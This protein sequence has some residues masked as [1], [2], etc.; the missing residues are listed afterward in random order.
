MIPIIDAP[1]APRL[2][3]LR[4]ALTVV[5]LLFSTVVFAADSWVSVASSEGS[6]PLVAGNSAAPLF[7]SPEDHAGV[8]KVAAHLQA[9]IL[10]VS[11]KEPLLNSRDVP[12]GELVVIIGTLGKS[13]LIDKLAASGKIDVATVMGRWETFGI[14]SVE[15]PMPEVGRALVIFGSDKRGTIYGMYEL[16][17][18][19][20][21]SP[22]YW[23]ADA[24]V[25]KKAEIH[26]A[27]G[28]HTLGEPKVKYRGIFINDEAPALR[29]WAAEKFGGHN[30]KFYE[31]VFELILRNRGNYLWPAMWLPTAFYEDDPENA[32]L[33]DEYGVIMATSH[34]E[35]MTRA[36]DEWRRFGGGAWNYKTNP[37]QLREFWR[38]GV[39]RM[40]DYETVVTVG[41][42]GDGDEAMAEETAVDLLKT[43]IG[44][45]RSILE[46]VT[47]KPAGDIPQ[48]WALYKE[49]QDYYQRG[50]RVDEDILVLFSDDNWGNIR[51]LPM[52]NE[53]DH[54]GGYGM[55]YHVDYVGAPVSYRWLN[56]SQIERIWEQMT[57]TY[58]WGVDRLW[59]VNVGD[60]KPMELPMSFFLD[61]AWDPEA[62][63]AG[64]LP[65]YYRNW[66]GQQFGETYA[67]EISG[68]L[69]S[70]T[71]YNARRTPEMLK[72]DTYSVE[73]Y[74]E[75]DR[76][77][78]EYRQLTE[79]ARALS[80]KL[81]ESHKS[82]Y[83]QLVLY[84]IEA[85]SNINEM[86]VAAGKN[87]YYATRGAAFANHYAEQVMAHFERD[88]ELARY[89]H[90]ELQQGK[91]NHMMSQTRMGYTYWNHPPLDRTPAVYY[92]RLDES[93][94]LGYFVEHGEIPKW[95]WLDVEAD[96][97]FSSS[98]PRFDPVNDQD[99][100]IEIINRGNSDLSWSIA[101][102]EDWILLSRRHGTVRHGEKVF[103]AIDWEKAPAGKAVGELTISGAGSEYTVKVPIN[104][105]MPD[106]AGYIENAGVVSIEAA[107]FQQGVSGSKANWIT[108]PNLGRTGSSVTPSPAIAASQQ[109]RTG[110]P[111]LEY[112]FT[113]LESGQVSVETH[114]SPTLNFKQGEGLKFAIAI[115]DQESRIVNINEDE[116]DPDWTYPPWWENSVADHIKIKRSEHGRIEAG[117]HTL[118]VWMIDPGIVIQKF[119]IDTGGLRSSYLGPPTSKFVEAD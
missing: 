77:V 119:V 59:I 67:E 12:S 64:D 21:V 98:M 104:N 11:D 100:Y 88:A 10:R 117:K 35:P 96:W 41:M 25:R 70:Y 102:R 16:S 48:V 55:Y 43:I 92:V 99:Y 69:A 31:H 5:F 74:R 19:S 76:V 2:A 95:G 72:P 51:I 78:E 56:V 14:Q 106:L 60:I 61:L 118:K 42:R 58:Q 8:L 87:A 93:A 47:G 101:A 49:V 97:S 115:D 116:K 44:D 81:P 111:A 75:A 18:H 53:E 24:P 57:I 17:R 27:S 91:W 86:I 6:F 7:V 68:L 29:R 34:H 54:P 4:I 22:W 80:A 90:E 84:P 38:G 62:I 107:R 110:S 73:N 26:V 1:L 52:A 32:R 33:A 113:L 28:F 94:I 9:D 30:H 114:V 20:G 50:M 105:E 63:S 83:F 109:T 79:Q 15:E 108:V 3:G 45:Q 36:H 65:A 13:P 103:V 85:S 112:T 46:D 40:V 37:E 23:W 66:A 89:F 39:E 71:K 82:A